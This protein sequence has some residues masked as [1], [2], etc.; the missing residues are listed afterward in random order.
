MGVSWVHPWKVKDVL[1]PW[2]RRIKK[3]LAFGI[4][5][6]I[7]LAIW[8]STWKERNRKIFE[9]KDLSLHDFRLY[10]LKILYSWSQ[11]LDG[12]ANTTFV[13]FLDNLMQGY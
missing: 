2:R 5:K 12:G 3:C 4:W 13:D 8:W 9:G 1:V 6:L 7:P 11:A 10:F